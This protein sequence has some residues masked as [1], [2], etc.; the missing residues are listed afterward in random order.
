MHRIV[1]RNSLANRSS[2]SA[3]PPPVRQGK[4]AVNLR[5]FRV[6]GGEKLLKFIERINLLRVLLAKFQ[7]ALQQP[8]LD[9]FEQ[10]RDVF[11]GL[12]RLDKLLVLRPTIA[13]C[14]RHRPLLQIAG[15][16][17]NPH[18]HTFFD[19]IPAF[20]AAAEFALI[21]MN[22]NRFIPRVFAAKLL[23]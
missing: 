9:F 5:L 8:R 15:A 17:F 23:R 7:R 21:D 6:L 13:P 1:T 2:S 18:R 22:A 16:D 3:V 19:P 14:N 20:R 10:T 4:S 11:H 12:R